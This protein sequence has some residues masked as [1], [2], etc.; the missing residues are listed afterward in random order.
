[1]NIKFIGVYLELRFD[2]PTQLSYCNNVSP[3]KGIKFD[4]PVQ[5]GEKA[6]TAT[7]IYGGFTSIGTLF[8]DKS[9]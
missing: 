3:F 1:M 2:R 5:W 7:T 8:R 6:Q 9:F 4:G